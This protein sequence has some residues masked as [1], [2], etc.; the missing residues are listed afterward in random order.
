MRRWLLAFVAIVAT[1][2]AYADDDVSQWNGECCNTD[3]G[4]VF[5][6][7]ETLLWK[8]CRPDMEY[9]LEANTALP[10]IRN[11]RVHEMEFSWGVGMRLALGHTL[12]C[13]HWDI[14]LQYTRFHPK[15]IGSLVDSDELTQPQFY[16]M[17]FHPGMI[18]PPGQFTHASCK[19]KIS[20]DVIDLLVGHYFCP[21][22]SLT[23]RPYGGVRALFLNQR[24]RLH[25]MGGAFIEQEIP[26]GIDQVKWDSE[27]KAFGFHGGSE[28]QCYFCRDLSVYANFGGSLLVGEP[29]DFQIQTSTQDTTTLVDDRQFDFVE[30]DYY[31]M[32]CGCNAAIG[33][34]WEVCCLDTLIAVTLGYEMHQWNGIPDARRF[35][36]DTAYGL[37]TGR[38]HTHMGFH[39]L[40]FRC[41]ADY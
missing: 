3:C 24:M 11:G 15:A 34:M 21:C 12:T 18:N 17:R 40:F 14:Q 5:F 39:G 27:Y 41:R 13:D 33:L 22:P 31:Q 10:L 30:N 6:T 36:S 16:Q 23:L 1:V 2:A 25:Y 8:T 29:E 20:Y 4:H 26:G 35:T 7:K 9:G 38:R 37:N 19:L 28:W 32:T